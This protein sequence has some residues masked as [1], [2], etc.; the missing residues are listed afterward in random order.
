[1]YRCLLFFHIKKIIMEQKKSIFRLVWGVL[2]VVVYLG[3]AYLLVFTSLFKET[4]PS[5]LRLIFGA[6]F[7]LYGVYRGYRVWKSGI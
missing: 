1:M 4:M 3:M 7:T 6:L 5:T 2:M